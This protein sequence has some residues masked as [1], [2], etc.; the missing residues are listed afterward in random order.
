MKQIL[1]KVKFSL[2]NQ[3]AQTP[4]GLGY[5]GG[6]VHGRLAHAEHQGA[7]EEE[8]RAGGRQEEVHVEEEMISRSSTC[9]SMGAKKIKIK[10]F[11]RQQ[12]IPAGLVWPSM[13]DF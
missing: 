7:R 9:S 10:F 12:K 2:P 11:I 3:L 4:G 8:A 13:S 5:G 1:V 6:D